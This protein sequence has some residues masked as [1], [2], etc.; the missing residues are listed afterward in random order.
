MVSHM[1]MHL[2]VEVVSFTACTYRQPNSSPMNL[3]G[4]EK[5]KLVL[6]IRLQYSIHSL[7]V[8]LHHSL[9]VLLHHSPT[10]FHPPSAPS[11]PSTTCILLSLHYLL[12]FP[13]T[14]WRW[15]ILNFPESCSECV[16]MVTS[17]DVGS[18]KQ[19]A[20]TELLFAESSHMEI[21]TW[22]SSSSLQ[23]SVNW[24]Q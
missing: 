3:T 13:S 18:V 22:K 10:V 12:S 15:K 17:Q 1:W 19:C 6:G 23:G 2:V 24:C 11:L 7:T 14:I 4:F 9:T 21:Y 5:G 20:V 8:L 16:R